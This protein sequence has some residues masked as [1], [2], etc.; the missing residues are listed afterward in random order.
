MQK[1][2]EIVVAFPSKIVAGECHAILVPASRFD[3]YETGNKWRN[4]G[5]FS[6]WQYGNYVDAITLMGGQIR[7][8]VGEVL[9]VN[10]FDMKI[11]GYVEVKAIKMIVPSEITDADIALMG[12]RD[13]A[14]WLEMSADGLPNRKG[15]WL[16]EVQTVEDMLPPESAETEHDGLL[17]I[18]IY[19][20][21]EKTTKQ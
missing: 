10:G 21:D 1:I 13:R 17:Q 7:Y 3:A 5:D 2:T 20:K 14:H 15:G 6:S 4:V 18:D 11:H 9:A 16:F 12:W 8:T 19:G